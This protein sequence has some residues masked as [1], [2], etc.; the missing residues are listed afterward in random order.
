MVHFLMLNGFF[1]A[2][3][4]VITSLPAFYSN[5]LIRN[6][7]YWLPFDY[8]GVI[9]GMFILDPAINNSLTDIF[10]YS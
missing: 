7:L 3:I 6:S 8:Y 5:D 10:R 1:S 4:A 2:V 9:L